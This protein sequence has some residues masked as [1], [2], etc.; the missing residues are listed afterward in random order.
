MEPF[1]KPYS[2]SYKC[3]NATFVIWHLKYSAD[4]IAAAAAT[5][6]EL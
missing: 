4:A 5:L 6:H 2:Y 1:Q 3:S